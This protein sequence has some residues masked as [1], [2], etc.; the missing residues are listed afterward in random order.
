MI[1]HVTANFKRK[2]HVTGIVVDRAA[3]IALLPIE[4]FQRGFPKGEEGERLVQEYNTK[5]ANARKLEAPT[6]Q[7]F[8]ITGVLCQRTGASEE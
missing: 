1:K 8:S 2:C 7:Q 4:M 6:Y 3:D 5:K